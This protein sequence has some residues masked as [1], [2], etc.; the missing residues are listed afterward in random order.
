MV[1][2][3]LDNGSE[4]SAQDRVHI[5]VKRCNKQIV[6]LLV[7]SGVKVNLVDERGCRPLHYTA[8]RNYR[9]LTKLL[10]DGHADV[11]IW[12][13]KG[14]TAMDGQ[15]GRTVNMRWKLLMARS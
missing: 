3:L 4:L 13:M 11:T 1:V 7:A 8:Q 2:L 9:R 5:A 12:D 14:R 6:G 10:L 15:K